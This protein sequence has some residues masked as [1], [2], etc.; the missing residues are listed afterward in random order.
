MRGEMLYMCD[1][2]NNRIL[3]IERKGKQF[4]ADP[5][6]RGDEGRSANT[7]SQPYDVFVDPEGNIYVADYGN[8]RVVN[9]GPGP[10]LGAG[11]REAHRRHV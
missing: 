7:F 5:D 10:E 2:S 9:D 6:H 8:Q 4:D 1:T 11:L 3:E